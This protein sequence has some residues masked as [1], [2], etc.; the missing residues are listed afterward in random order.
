VI[1]AVADDEILVS[2]EIK[3]MQEISRSLW[4][5]GLLGCHESK[6]LVVERPVSLTILEPPVKY[7]VTGSKGVTFTDFRDVPEATQR[8]S[9]TGGNQ[10]DD[11][12]RV[13]QTYCISGAG[14][15]ASTRVAL[16][17][18]NCSSGY[19]GNTPAGDRCVLVRGTVG[20]CGADRGPFNVWLGCRGRGWL[21][22]DVQ[23]TR[24]EPV[25]VQTPAEQF[26]VD[27]SLGQV[28]FNVPLPATTGL[29][30]PAY[31]YTAD[32]LMKQG[33]K[34]VNTYAV[35]HANPNAGPVTSRAGNG[36]LSLEI[37]Q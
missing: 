32:V 24:R 35:S 17:S 14:T 6:H 12:Y 5:W 21:E 31:V 33:R 11:N 13:D 8:Y 26:S 28:S 20:G 18:A 10:C 23:L 1:K 22:Y 34:V 25:P 30:S 19:E 9:N 36:V 29:T 4:L 15:L 7:A 2:A 27:G 37:A 3:G 16:V